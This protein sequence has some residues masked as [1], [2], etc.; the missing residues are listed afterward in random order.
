[1]S[2][3]NNTFQLSGFLG[4][5][6]EKR[7]NQNNGNAIGLMSIGVDSSYKNRETGEVVEHTDWFDLTVYREGLIKVI[8]QYVRKGSEIT[9]RGYMRKRTW[10]SKDR[11]NEDGTP[12]MD[13][14]YEFVV[15][16]IRLGR[17][18]KGSDTNQATSQDLAQANALATEAS[19][20][21]PDYDDDIP[22]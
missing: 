8:D 1:M 11:I 14:R 9:V 20:A 15:T 18:P 19:A 22:Y 5:D 21:S 16:E 2:R 3:I 12:R 7:F 6:P 10:E 17:R 4:A 13:S